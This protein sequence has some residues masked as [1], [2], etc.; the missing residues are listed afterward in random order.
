M[1]QLLLNA[2][3]TS[4]RTVGLHARIL[5]RG[6]RRAQAAAAAMDSYCTR[7]A[8]AA[9]RRGRPL[10]TRAPLPS[11][12]ATARTVLRAVLAQARCSRQHRFSR[13]L[14]LCRYRAS[15]RAPLRARR[16]SVAEAM[17]LCDEDRLL[18]AVEAALA[19]A[20]LAALP[21]ELRESAFRGGSAG[22]RSPLDAAASDDAS[23]AELS[24][25]VARCVRGERPAPR[26]LFVLRSTLQ[27][28]AD[29][30][31]DTVRAAT[32]PLRPAA[33]AL[34]AHGPAAALLAGILFSLALTCSLARRSCSPRRS[35]VPMLST[36]PG[37]APCTAK[38]RRATW[39]S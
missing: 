35:P 29:V 33:A 12:L 25:L 10:L 23:E 4:R 36:P 38:T 18:S 15:L 37:R 8:R 30:G 22:A 19:V 14:P 9:K 6:A 17:L 1:R 26:A 27:W 21:A 13:R 34:P 11:L 5:L 28:R 39:S 3:I 16:R 24:D 20:A 2:L 31:A 32:K 7:H